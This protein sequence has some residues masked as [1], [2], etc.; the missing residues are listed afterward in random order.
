MTGIIETMISEINTVRRALR[1]EYYLHFRKAYVREQM[2][3]RKGKCGRHGCCDFSIVQ[4]HLRCYDQKDHSIC[5]RWGNQPLECRIYP[6]DEDD[7]RPETK[8]Y[9]NF[10]WE[11]KTDAGKKAKVKR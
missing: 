7:K 11:N 4:K 9:C 2:K 1:R 8:G 3:N 10:H 5:L 6:F